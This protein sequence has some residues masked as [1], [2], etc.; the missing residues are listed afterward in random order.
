MVIR[1]IS[2]WG[3]WFQRERR[4]EVVQSLGCLLMR[5]RY[6]RETSISRSGANLG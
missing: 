3:K 5:V 6:V 4:V 2:V 1:V